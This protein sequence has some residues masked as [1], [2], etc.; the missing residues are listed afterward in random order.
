MK[1]THPNNPLARY[2]PPL[3]DPPPPEGLDLPAPPSVE[4]I[5]A[6]WD[7]YEM[8]EHIRAHSAMVA[9]LAHHIALLG[10]EKGLD[11]NPDR[12]LAAGLLHDI[13]KTYS[14]LHGGNHCQV[15]AAWALQATGDLLIASAVYH[16]VYWPF[17]L[18]T[19]CYFTQLAV[20]YSDK[21]VAHTNV[22]SLKE[23]FD[24]LI[25]RYGLTPIARK[26]IGETHRQAL[27]LE[28]ALSTT[29]G[30]D[31]NACTFDRGRLVQ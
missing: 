3:A 20:L 14:V 11:V 19:E 22:V 24:D 27:D 28:S 23:R 8:A 9:K 26:R 4:A 31:L 25:V 16:H 6:L 7:E 29:V 2:L 13:A 10:A 21:R 18:D 1:A 5:R 30:V 17:T 12:V 15:G